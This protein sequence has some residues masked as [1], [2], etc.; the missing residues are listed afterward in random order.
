M[1]LYL[2]KLF[3][4]ALLPVGLALLL[5]LLAL[6]AAVVGRRRAAGLLLALQ[7]TLLWVS[8]MPW[9][10][11]RLTLWL[12]GDFPPVALAD[13]PNADV[14]VVLGGGVGRLGEP[15]VENLT[16]A[17]DR[18][19]RAARLYRAGKVG[20]LMAVG[21]NLPWSGYR[22]PESALM[23]DLLVEWGVPK[24]AILLETRSQNTRENALFGAETLS[25]QA[26]DRV[27]LV[28]S[29]A[30]MKRAVGAFRAVG[31]DVI[32]SPTDYAVLPASV[33]L[34]QSEPRGNA[35]DEQMDRSAAEASPQP[36]MDESD[37]PTVGIA[38]FLPTVEALQ[39][40]TM[41]IQEVLGRTY[42]RLRG[43]M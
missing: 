39:R 1:T 17:S 19:L 41:V 27:L 12:E 20:T 33:P 7:V 21:G 13:T 37:G 11:M 8:S 30:H 36:C 15:P 6:G 14:A 23:R 2:T 24:D 28:T 35:C 18:V 4:L 29:A 22:T 43:W 10:S 40:T 16:S 5:G 25:A 32:P 3:T 38:S 42:Y 9:A 34:A 26:W 31:V